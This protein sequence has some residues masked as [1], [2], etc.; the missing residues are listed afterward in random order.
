MNNTIIKVENLSKRYRIGTRENGYKNFREAIIDGFTAP[1]RNF[2]RLRKLSHFDDTAL[3]DN[4]KLLTNNQKSTPDNRQQITD[5]S[6]QSDVIWALK[7]VSFEV[8]QGEVVG[9]IGRNGSGKSTLLKILS[10][11]TEPTS[12]EVKL[13]GRVSSLLEVGTG[14]H[15]ELTGR[16]NIYLNGAIL[17]MRKVEIESK[18]D[19]IVDFAE[20]DKF[21]DTPVKRYSSG[22]YVRLAFAVAA[23]LEPEILLVDEVLAVGDIEFQKKCLGKMRS[24]TGEGRTILFVSHNMAAI[25]SLCPRTFLLENGELVS[26]TDTE[27]AV[28]KY[29]DKNIAEGAIVSSKEFEAN[30]EGVINRNNP[31]IRLK[32]IALVDQ[33]DLLRNVFHSDESFRVSV[34]YECLTIVHDLRVVVQ[35]VDGENQPILTTQSTD[36]SSDGKRFYRREPGVYKSLCIIPPNTFGEKRFYVTVQLLYPKVDH[37]ILKKIIGFD[38]SF[39]GYSNVQYAPFENSFIRPQLIWETQSLNKKQEG[40]RG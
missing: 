9:I 17:G 27:C 2:K 30:V 4:K 3:P 32:E 20:I 6:S 25:R 16:E 40:V 24:V 29:L 28:A 36:D 1:I 26:D 11:I 23:Y 19:E 37:L 39:Q 38:V 21:I 33:Q 5:N 14:F 10:R 13:H 35:I 18:F 7:D 12:G 34:T 22:M 8:K 15:L 31:S